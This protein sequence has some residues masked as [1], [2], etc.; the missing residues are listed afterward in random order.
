[1]PHDD[2]NALPPEQWRREKDK[3]VYETWLK[4]ARALLR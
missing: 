1:M 4:N 3:Y 2:L